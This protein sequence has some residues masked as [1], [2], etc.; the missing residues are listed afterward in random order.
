MSN[1]FKAIAR[2][3]LTCGFSVLLTATDKVWD[4]G[5]II[6]NKAIRAALGLP[7]YTSLKYIYQLTN[8]PRVKS[9]SITLLQPVIAKANSNND[10]HKNRTI[11]DTRYRSTYES[12]FEHI[13]SINFVQ[14]NSSAFS[15]G[16]C[17]CWTYW[18]Q[19]N[20]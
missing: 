5:Q 11:M 3:V 15:N 17:L 18:Q 10:K 12:C 1:V 8:I 13:L 7:F 2:T 16:H 9:F 20:N 4:Q 14:F 6:H 19:Y